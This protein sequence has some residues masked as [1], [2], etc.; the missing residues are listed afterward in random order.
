[1]SA[2]EVRRCARSERTSDA[3]LVVAVVRRPRP[4]R[5][6]LLVGVETGE[7][8][9]GARPRARSGARTVEVDAEPLERRSIGSSIARHRV[10]SRW[11]ARRRSRPDSRPRAAPRPRR[12]RL[13]GRAEPVHLRAGVVVVVLALDLVPGELEQPCDRVP[14]GGVAGR[15]DG[16]RAGRIGRDHLHLDPLAAESRTPRPNA[17]PRREDP[18]AAPRRT[19]RRRGSRLRNPGRPPRRRVDGRKRR[20]RGR[21]L[22]GHLQ[23]RPPR[24]RREP[25]RD[26]RRVVAVLGRRAARATTASR[27]LAAT[28]ASA[29]TA[30]PPAG[31]GLRSVRSVVRSPR[32]LDRQPPPRF[33]ART[34]PRPEAA[35]GTLRLAR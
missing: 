30:A 15:R 34:M 17:A 32:A 28:P 12:A 16:D 23:R 1:M 25:Q 26:V 22:L 7:R 31:I 3:V 9:I 13:D 33:A 6:V 20:G 14:V 35:G 4:E 24:E 29:T 10:A 2:R 18:R 11:R 5:A 21:E 27:S 19:T 8:R